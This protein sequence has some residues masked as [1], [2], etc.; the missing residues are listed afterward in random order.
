MEDK[1]IKENL[2]Y[3]KKN[4]PQLWLEVILNNPKML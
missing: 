3:L 2:E 4:A 1:T